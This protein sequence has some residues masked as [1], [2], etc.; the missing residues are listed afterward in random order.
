MIKLEKTPPGYTRKIAKQFCALPLVRGPVNPCGFLLCK[1][2]HTV[3]TTILRSKIARNLLVAPVC[4]LR[5]H[6]GAVCRWCAREGLQRKAH[7]K[8][9]GASE[10]WERNARFFCPRGAGK[11][12]RPD[13]LKKSFL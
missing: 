10:D 11:K 1:K 3:T 8:R 2:P 7:R 6:T 9:L 13:F 4:M 5:I 12:T